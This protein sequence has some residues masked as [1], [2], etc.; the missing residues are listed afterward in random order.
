MTTKECIVSKDHGVFYNAVMRYVSTLHEVT[1]IPY[2][3]LL[4]G[5]H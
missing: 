2:Y 5:I 4:V 3:C 1:V